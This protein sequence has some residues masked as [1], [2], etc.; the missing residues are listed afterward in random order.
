MANLTPAEAEVLNTIRD[1]LIG[2]LRHCTTEDHISAHFASYLN[3]SMILYSNFEDYD[4]TVDVTPIDI[5]VRV[6][7]TF[8]SNISIQHKLIIEKDDT[9]GAAYNRAMGVI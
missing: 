3:R 1:D 4:F 5:S 6:Y 7:I 8:P 9:P 2:M